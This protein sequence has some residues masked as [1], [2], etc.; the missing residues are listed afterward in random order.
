MYTL[1]IVIN[2]G[3]MEVCDRLKLQYFAN[4][5]NAVLHKLQQGTS[6][7]LNDLEMNEILTMATFL[8]PRFK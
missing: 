8:D 7:R 5:A 3:L 6:L 2:N 4:R 1:A